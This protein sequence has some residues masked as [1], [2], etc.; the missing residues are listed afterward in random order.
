MKNL[1]L[2]IPLALS[3]TSC[4][5]HAPADS[6]YVSATRALEYI[7]RNPLDMVSYPY[8]GEGKSSEKITISYISAGVL[9]RTTFVTA[10]IPSYQ[11]RVKDVWDTRWKLRNPSK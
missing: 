4:D 3:L 2:I 8:W 5:P 1:L 9:L 11:R 7:G 10:E 6:G